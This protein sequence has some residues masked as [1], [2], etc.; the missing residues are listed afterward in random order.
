MNKINKIHE[1]DHFEYFMVEITAGNSVFKFRIKTDK[2]SK[3][4]YI[5]IEDIIEASKT[6]K[7]L[8]DFLSSDSGLDLM[9]E[10]LKENPG[11]NF[12]DL[13]L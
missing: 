1:D 4:P 5:N 3:V 12:S 6:D 9:N 13:F 8:H 11:M 7:T 10:V 2:I